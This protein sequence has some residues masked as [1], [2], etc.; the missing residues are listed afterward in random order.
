[1]DVVPFYPLVFQQ[2]GLEERAAAHRVID[3]GNLTMG[4]EVAA[5]ER[6]FADY[7]GR[8]FAVMTNSGSSANLIATGAL[9]QHGI[10]KRG[11]YVAV[12]ALAWSTTYA[13][14]H[15]YGLK[16]HVMDIDPGTLMAVGRPDEMVNVTVPILG[17]PVPFSPYSILEDCCES[18]GSEWGGEKSGSFGMVSTF[19][20]FHSHQLST[21]EGGMVLTDNEYI[22]NC[23]RMLRAHGWD[24]DIK[25][26][27]PLYRFEVPGFNVRPMEIAAA[28]GR[29]QLKKLPCFIAERRKNWKIYQ[30]LFG[31]DNRWI[32]QREYSPLAKSS[33]F[34]FC[35]TLTNTDRAVVFEALTAAGIEHRMITG[36]CFTEHPSAKF[37]DYKADRLPHA[38]NVHR[39]GFFVGNAPRDLEPQLIKLREVLNEVCK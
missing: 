36:G 38:L 34:A 28:M 27:S 1:M 20:F 8:K 21:G 31:N 10:F 5:F 23:L 3:S 16:L 2:H 25:G 37:Y 17:N 24:R 9:I 19:S 6:E 4:E 15:L 29:E 39:N 22:Y 14:L 32:I 35:F 30:E 26:M 7:H 18:L 13:P 11:E 12:P 33:A